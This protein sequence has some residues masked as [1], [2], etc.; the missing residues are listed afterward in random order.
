MQAPRARRTATTTGR[1]ARLAS[2]ACLYD[3]SGQRG[4]AT[5]ANDP[6]NV[7]RTVDIIHYLAQDV[8]DMISVVQLLNEVAAYTSDTFAKAVRQYWLDGYAAVRD[9]AG[10]NVQVMIGDAFEGVQAWSGFM[11]PPA[12]QGVLMDYVRGS[13]QASITTRR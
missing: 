13:Q 4:A 3:F 9:G 11:Q 2:C 1:R 7:A 6:N 10:S 12:Y 5:W 8:G